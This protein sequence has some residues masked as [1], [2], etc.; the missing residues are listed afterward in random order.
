MTQQPSPEDDKIRSRRNWF[1]L[2][3]LLGFVVL[4]FVVTIVKLKS[5]AAPHF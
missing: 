5:N 2:V 1:M 4:V 3:A